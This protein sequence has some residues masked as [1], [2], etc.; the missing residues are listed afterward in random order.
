MSKP[1]DRLVHR[2]GNG[3]ANVRVGAKRAERIYPRQDE[4]VRAAR[5]NLKNA[6]GGELTIQGRDGRFR[7]KNT[8]TPGNDPFPPRDKR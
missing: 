2:S 8:I 1:Q 3:W 5:E 6:G 4:A 7:D